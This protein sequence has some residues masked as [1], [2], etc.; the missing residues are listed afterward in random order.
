MEAWSGRLKEDTLWKGRIRLE[1]D[2]VVPKGVR[3]TL[4]PGAKVTAAP[5]PIWSCAVFR[6]APEG[7]PIET[8]SRKFCDIVV[9]GD[10]QSKG[11][12]ADPVRLGDPDNPWGG[13]TWLSKG[14]GS[15]EW[16]VIQNTQ[17]SILQTFDHSLLTLKN[18]S[19]TGPQVGIWSWGLS[20]VRFS[21]GRIDV[22]RCGVLCCDGSTVTLQNVTVRKDCKE[23]FTSEKWSKVVWEGAKC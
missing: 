13:M 22:P 12:E 7:Y 11:T 9:L 1:G 16:T 8:S 10:L 14:R 18:C 2:V 6:S 4:A 5:R 17:E 19:L 23:A 15:L 21:G 20:E 3:L